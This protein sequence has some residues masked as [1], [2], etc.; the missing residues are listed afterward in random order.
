[1]YVQSAAFTDDAFKLNEAM[2]V[3]QA[4]L[5]EMPPY[6][7]QHDKN[8]SYLHMLQSLEQ[9]D[10]QAEQEGKSTDAHKETVSATD[11]QNK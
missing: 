7:K 1:M 9:S 2:R 11:V 6:K 5:D 3:L 4:H 8:K 10:R